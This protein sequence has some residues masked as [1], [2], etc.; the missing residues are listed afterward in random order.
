MVRR[1]VYREINWQEG[2]GRLWRDC[3]NV[4]KNNIIDVKVMEYYKARGSGRKHEISGDKSFFERNGSYLST[5]LLCCSI[6]R[7]VLHECVKLN[8]HLHI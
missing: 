7:S 3:Q 5:V 1:R 6:K 2:V 8:V 4:D